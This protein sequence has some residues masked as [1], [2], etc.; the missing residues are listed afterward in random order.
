MV[1]AVLKNDSE[2][3]GW[4]IPRGLKKKNHQNCS[5]SAVS[6]KKTVRMVCA[7]RKND[8]E[9]SEKMIPVNNH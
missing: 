3:S 9:S 2:P 7:A 8:S 6:S 1:L 5:R 4:T